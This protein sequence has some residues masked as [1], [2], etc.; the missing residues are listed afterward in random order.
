VLYILRP[1][2]Y[3]QW[4]SVIFNIDTQDLQD[5]SVLVSVD[6][7]RKWKSVVFNIDMQDRQDC[8][9]YTPS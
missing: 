2:A 8:A 5:C 7:Y 9:L 1:D 3:R 4:K 6:T